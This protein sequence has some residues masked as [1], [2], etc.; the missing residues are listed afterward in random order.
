ML[1]PVVLHS[2]DIE[3]AETN[4]LVS[5][6][7]DRM[8]PN[9]YKKKLQHRISQNIYV[10]WLFGGWNGNTGAQKEASGLWS[11]LQTRRRY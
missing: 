6:A 2:I 8:N 4:E 7:F 11:N 3:Y 9:G 1:N 5:V 10:T